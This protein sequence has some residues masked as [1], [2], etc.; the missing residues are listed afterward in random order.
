MISAHGAGEAFSLV[1]QRVFDVLFSTIGLICLAPLFVVIALLLKFSGEGQIFFLQERVGKNRKSIKVYKFVTMM[2]GSENMGTGT[3]TM[4]GD[5]RILPVGSI[6]RKTKL[7]ELPQLVNILLGDMSVI[8]PR[9]QTRRC[10]DGFPK[11]T[12]NIITR[13]RPGLSGIGPIVFRGEEDILDGQLG[14]LKFYDDVIAPY[15][16]KVESWY[17]FNQSLGLYFSLIFLTIWVVLFSKSDLVWKL[18]PRI[19]IPPEELKSAL[20]YPITT[21]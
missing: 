15:K 20:N 6:L 10:F 9:P 4:K 17:I 3:V 1:H 13:V 2:E 14:S 11:E 5:P 21:I 19:P 7:N 12:Q 18:Y 16:G 8:G